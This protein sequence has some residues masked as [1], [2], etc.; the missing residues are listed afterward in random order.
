[1]QV[2]FQVV[3]DVL[4]IR[5]LGKLNKP[6]VDM[7]AFFD[8]LQAFH[9]IIEHGIVPLSGQPGLKSH[10]PIGHSRE[11]VFPAV[12]EIVF[13]FLQQRIRLGV[14]LQ[15]ELVGPCLQQTIMRP[16]LFGQHRN[17]Q[18]VKNLHCAV[19]L[20]LMES[21][22]LIEHVLLKRRRRLSASRQR[23]HNNE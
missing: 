2:V 19:W 15:Q 21:F 4:L 22:H 17:F 5:L 8:V 13:G 12:G 14:E 20:R 6:S 3:D 9:A 23:Q 7:F 16:L 11:I 1:M 10:S 18:C